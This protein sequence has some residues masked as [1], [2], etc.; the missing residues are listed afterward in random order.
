MVEKFG[1]EGIY[2]VHAKKGYELHEERIN[3]LFGD[4]GLKH[5]FVTDGDP[6][7]FTDELLGKYF[8]SN[9]HDILG[10]GILS[11]TLNHILSYE[12]MV[13]NGNKYALVFEN[14]PFF[15]GDFVDKIE[16]IVKEADNLKPGF[17][18][19]LEN[20]TLEFPPRKTV[21]KDKL[22]YKADRGRCAGGYLIDLEGAKAAL[23]DLKTRKCNY[24]IDWWHNTMISNNVIDAYW[25]HPPILEQGSHNGLM[26]STISSKQKSL[27]R[28]FAWKAQKL[29]KTHVLRMF[30]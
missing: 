18:I 17:I 23:E 15:I 26:C 1:I 4:L 25:A 16:K 10:K 9:I 14:D 29:Y 12:K 2:I 28:Q 6:S 27:K 24:V 5:E 21:R 19:S 11:C 22:V 13:Q 20:T 8:V 3:N 30:K 7:C